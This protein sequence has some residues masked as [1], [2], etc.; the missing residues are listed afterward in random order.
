MPRVLASRRVHLFSKYHHSMRPLQNRPRCRQCNRALLAI[1]A[2]DEIRTETV[3]LDEGGTDVRTIRTRGK[4]IGHGYG[5][6]DLFCSL[7][8]GHSWAVARLRVEGG[9]NGGNST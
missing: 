3:A 7:T 9:T 6:T 8:C 4:L 1:H 5:A 2:S